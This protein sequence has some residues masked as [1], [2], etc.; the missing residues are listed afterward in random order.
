MIRFVIAMVSTISLLF[1]AVTACD[2]F[3][4][5]AALIAAICAVPIIDY[6]KE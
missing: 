6:V 4:R 1:L 3:T 2:G 5:A